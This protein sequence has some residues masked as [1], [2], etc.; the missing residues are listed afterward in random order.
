[1]PEIIWEP[2]YELTP[3]ELD[4]LTALERRVRW[5]EEDAGN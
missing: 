4:D 1:M 3:S 2:E 5:E